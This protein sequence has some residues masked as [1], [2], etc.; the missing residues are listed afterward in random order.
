MCKN[1]LTEIVIS[2]IIVQRTLFGGASNGNGF[3]SLF[4]G[5][6]SWN[7]VWSGE[8]SVRW[9]LCCTPYTIN[10]LTGGLFSSGSLPCP[11]PRCYENLGQSW[12]APGFSFYWADTALKKCSVLGDGRP[13][14]M[15]NSIGND[16][17]YRLYIP[18]SH[19]HQSRS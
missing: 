16:V 7:P 11:S 13:M 5:R 2:P 8:V 1:V 15:V 17:R 3:K 14:E 10:Q 6:F 12:W 4:G 9:T 18:T 19:L